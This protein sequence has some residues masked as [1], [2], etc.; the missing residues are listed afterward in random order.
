[1]ANVFS[2]FDNRRY[3]IL[4]TIENKG[5]LYYNFLWEGS[6]FIALDGIKQQRIYESL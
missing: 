1:M 4:K 2:F 3:F 5:R 6:D